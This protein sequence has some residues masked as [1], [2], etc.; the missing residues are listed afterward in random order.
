MHPRILRAVVFGSFFGASCFAH[1][2]R[3]DANGGH[4]DRRN[5]GYHYHGSGSPRSYNRAPSTPSVRPTPAP[6][7]APRNVRPYPAGPNSP[8]KQ[9]EANSK[10]LEWHKTQAAAGS[11]SAQYEMGMRHL[12]GDGVEQSCVKAREWLTKAAKQENLQAYEQLRMMDYCAEKKHEDGR[13]L[14]ST[15]ARSQFLVNTGYPR[16]RSGYV[17]THI[18]P[19]KE[20]GVD[21]LENY[22]WEESKRAL[23]KETWE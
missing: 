5:G 4:Y 14:Q 20:G 23:A 15:R 16:G 9:A 6:T 18:K 19:L 11:A 1:P 10:V 2:G 17:I 21:A 7:P 8:E 3:T 22:H 13:V 12:K